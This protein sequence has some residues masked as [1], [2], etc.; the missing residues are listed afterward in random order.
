[1]KKLNGKWLPKGE[2]KITDAVATTSQKYEDILKTT[3]QSREGIQ[4]QVTPKVNEQSLGDRTLSRDIIPYMRKRNIQITTHRMKPRTRF[5][6]YFDNVDVTSFT[7]PKLLEINM[8]SGVFQTGEKIHA[9]SPSDPSFAKSFNF[10]LAAP[11]HKEGPY[12][13]PTKVLTLNPY[14]NAAG[15]ST[16]YSTSSTILNVDTFSLAQ[17][18]QGDNFWDMW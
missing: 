18:V 14:D 10:R 13:A 15:I 5:Y 6:V 7:T 17:Q 16:V 9:N 12:N 3:Q 1:M 4:Y 11:N 2:G 8:T